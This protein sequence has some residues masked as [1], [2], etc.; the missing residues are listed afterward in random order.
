MCYLVEVV[1]G[2]VQVGVHASRR[3]IGDLDGVLQDALWDDVPLGGGRG[4]STNEHPE[5]LMAPLC[6]LLQ[7]FLQ[8][9]QPASHQVD[10]LQGEARDKEPAR[11][12]LKRKIAHYCSI[13]D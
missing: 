12:G 13:T 10:V 11:L 4:L 8:S 7:K 3:F 1:Q 5:V 9:A 6:M 2:L